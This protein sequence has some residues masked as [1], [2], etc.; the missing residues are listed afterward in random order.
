V[1]H[2]YALNIV[3][4]DS[5]IKLDA[6]LTAALAHRAPLVLAPAAASDTPGMASGLF[7]ACEVASAQVE[8]PVALLG[9]EPAAGDALT[10]AINSGCSAVCV[11]LSSLVFPNVVAE[12]KALAEIA[13]SCGVA[14]GAELPDHTEGDAA[15][16]NRPAIA[17]YIAIAERAD[18]DFLGI[19]I[20]GA[21][22]TGKRRAKLDYVRLRRIHEGT[23]IPLL[24]RIAGEMQPDQIHRLIESGLALV[25]HVD[26]NVPADVFKLWGGAGRAAEVLAQCLP[27]QPIAHV[28]EFN[29][30]DDALPEL[31]GILHEG[32]RRLAMIPGVRAVTTGEAIAGEA[33]YRYCWLVTFANERIVDYYRHHPIHT[34]FANNLF[35]PIAD[36]RLTIDFR[37]TGA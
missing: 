28:V 7:A 32:R 15:Q 20:G 34:S 30:R 1:L 10:G 14:I 11:E 3:P 18:L 29:V 33:R 36:D 17:A 9:L 35:R 13:K 4:I 25:Y 31:P 22:R 19:D 8:I 5:S 23:P 37:L 21:D 16:D 6:A 27:L 24:T 26:A 12:V 2:R